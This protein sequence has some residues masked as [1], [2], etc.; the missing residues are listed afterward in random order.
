MLTPSPSSMPDWSE[1]ETSLFSTTRLF[2]PEAS[3]PD[4]L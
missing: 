2:V 1:F 4:G 3:T